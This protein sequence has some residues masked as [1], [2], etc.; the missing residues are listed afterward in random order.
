LWH[1]IEVDG[2]SSADPSTP[3]GRRGRL[4]RRR[5]RRIFVLLPPILRILIKVY[6]K[7]MMLRAVSGMS[8][9]LFKTHNP[10]PF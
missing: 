1:R 8:V 2:E 4:R 5:R 10:T 6:K 3:L 9:G 7:C